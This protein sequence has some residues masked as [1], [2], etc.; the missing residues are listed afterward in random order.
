MTNAVGVV[1]EEYQV[2]RSVGERSEVRIDCAQ[3]GHELFTL[4]VYNAYKESRC[5]HDSLS[6]A[7]VRIPISF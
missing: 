7:G 5:V 4:A 3:D 2:A 1:D 6:S